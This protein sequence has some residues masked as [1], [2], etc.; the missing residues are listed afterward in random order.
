MIKIK[1]RVRYPAYA[2][3]QMRNKGA[4]TTT[5]TLKK[6]IAVFLMLALCV[7][8]L[9]TTAAAA[10]GLDN[11]TDKRSYVEGHFTDIGGKWF[12]GSV[13]RGYSLGLVDGKG[14]GI[15]DP[16]GSVTLAEAT[17]LAACLHSI[18]NTGEAAFT[19]GSPWYQVY[20]DYCLTKGV[21]SHGYPNYNAVA[22]REQFAQIFAGALP[23]SALP[24]INV[25]DDNAIPDVKMN[26]TGAAAIYRLYRAGILTG[27]DGQGTFNPASGIQRSEVAAIV[28]R[29]AD[30][31]LRKEV[32]LT[33]NAGDTLTAEQIAANC[34]S[35]VFYIEIYDKSGDALASGSG[36]FISANGRA[37]TN[38]HV[39]EDAYSAAIRTTDGKLH[40]VT[41]WY[42][43][44][45][46][47]D[48]AL[49][50]VDGTG[51]DY[52]KF[53][54]GTS[55]AAGQNIFAIG[56]PLGLDNTISQGI[57]S[58]PSRVVDGLDYIQIS[59]PISRGSSGG[60]LINDR[61]Q[62]IGITTAGF[63]DG[64]NLNLAVPI[65]YA[66]TLDPSTLHDFPLGSAG[67]GD[68]TGAFLRF[69]PTVTL[70]EGQAGSVTITADPGDYEDY[71]TVEYSIL[72]PN[73]VSVS[74]GDW[75][76]IDINLYLDAIGV[77]TTTVKLTMMTSET[78]EVLC[79]EELTVIV[80]PT[81]TS[82]EFYPGYSSVP[83]FSSV[84]GAELF[85]TK[86]GCYFYLMNEVD[87]VKKALYELALIDHGF[88]VWQRTTDSYGDPVIYYAHTTEDL[89]VYIAI[90]YISGYPC[91]E[92]CPYYGWE[93]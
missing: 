87:E 70:E 85:Y 14:D 49:I 68:S 80:T 76:G 27:S 5:R 50:Q 79:I 26:D 84:T 60:A 16:Q 74:W 39:L 34:S 22:T 57:I 66:N 77:G 30:M 28:T 75:S 44:D 11:F 72:N 52:L 40:D 54:D 89:Y 88:E 62:L 18:Y 17:K 55:L 83:D 23:A 37:L 61:G 43:A 25:V 32:H 53:G 6:H 8:V 9:S 82:E 65:S 3:F 19:Q 4:D 33:T 38:H 78:E 2:I 63:D 64:Q 15:F 69:E 90:N 31:D 81:P 12:E 10:T 58:N 47:C 42:D 56:S 13:A 21:L 73:I 91:L 36:V 71:Y 45:K 59:A 35:S 24:A 67:T 93:V 51:F 46:S 1:E 29:M 86:D 20:V 7:S 48:L 41:G 92:I